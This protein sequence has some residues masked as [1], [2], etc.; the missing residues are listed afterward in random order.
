MII[1]IFTNHV[2]IN[3]QRV[4]RPSSMSPSQWIAYW[5]N[6]TGK[7]DYEKKDDLYY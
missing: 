7:Y 1:E 3:G 5:E 4:E 2:V 6:A